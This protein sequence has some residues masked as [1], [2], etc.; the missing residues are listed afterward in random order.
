MR[1]GGDKEI[2]RGS[3]PLHFTRTVRTELIK[4]VMNLP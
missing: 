4:M 1:G 3:L 2:R